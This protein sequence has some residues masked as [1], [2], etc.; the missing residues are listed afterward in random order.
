MTLKTT[1]WKHQKEA[2]EFIRGRRGALLNMGMGTGKTLCA[3]AKAANKKLVMVACPLSVIPVWANEFKA[4]ADYSHRILSLTKGSCRKKGE[5]LTEFIEE[6]TEGTTSLVVVNYESAWRPGLKE[7]FLDTPWDLVIA[8]ESHRIKTPG[9]SVSKFFHRLWAFARE[10]LLLSG[11]PMSHSPLDIYSQ[12]KFADPRVFGTSFLKFRAR[13]AIMGGF[14]VNGRAVQVVGYQNQ[15]EM[16]RKMEAFTYTAK[17]SDV[18]DLPPASF[19]EVY[20][21]LDKDERRA[22]N[23]IKRDLVTDLGDGVVSAG[24]ALTRLLRLQQV[25]HGSTNTDEGDK[26]RLGRSRA[27]VL[28]EVLEGIGNEPV[29][30][31]C[32]FRSDIEDVRWAVDKL[33]KDAGP[34]K[35]RRVVE[36]SGEVK[37]IQGKWT[38]GDVAAVQ[39]RA[40]GLGIDLTRARYC[41]L[42]GVGFSLGDYEQVLA[43]VHRPGQD[44]PVTYIKVVGNDTIDEKVFGAL[45]D[46]RDV[47]ESVLGH[48]DV[49]VT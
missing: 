38:E 26:V 35:G 32:L 29:A 30:V 17:A 12:A 20:Y 19:T 31:I 36:L 16:A 11:T 42:Y 46:K 34:G 37:D 48:L 43:R 33:N 18:L 28:L 7:V 25:A 10:R 13:Y 40:G 45:G 27:K 23:E 5:L 39:I 49:V 2:I 8:D 4:H 24:N 3:I 9:S 15:E 14:A 6:A 21:D 41:V 44:R 47:V 22:F 1:P